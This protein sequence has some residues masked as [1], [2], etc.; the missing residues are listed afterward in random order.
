MRAS[1]HLEFF[2]GEAGEN[3]AVR[4]ALFRY[5]GCYIRPYGGPSFDHPSDVSSNG[6]VGL[7][8]TDF[9]QI[10]YIK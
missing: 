3:E 2:G 9:W 7:A 8:R 10:F 5:A 4:V 6:Q 1:A